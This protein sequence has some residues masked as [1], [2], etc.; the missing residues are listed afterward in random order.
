MQRSGDDIGVAEFLFRT[1]FKLDKSAC[2]I[3]N[4]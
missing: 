3:K 1:K 2:E 4:L